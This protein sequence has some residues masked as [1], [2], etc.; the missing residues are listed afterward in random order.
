[1]AGTYKAIKEAEVMRKEI[2]NNDQEV[3]QLFEKYV[4]VRDTIIDKKRGQIRYVKKSKKEDNSNL[5]FSPRELTSS[6]ARKLE[7]IPE[8]KFRSKSRSICNQSHNQ[9]Q[10]YDHNSSLDNNFMLP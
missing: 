1:M 7:T 2:T 5:V 6:I 8:G 4:K 10:V 3:E 9:S